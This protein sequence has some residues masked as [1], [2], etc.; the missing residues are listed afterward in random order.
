MNISEFEKTKKYIQDTEKI[1]FDDSF[2]LARSCSC[3]LNKDKTESLGRELVI[4]ILE[5]IQ[6][7][8]KRTHALWNDLV[9]VSGLEPYVDKK[10]LR[11]TAAIRH[12]YH[13]SISLPDVYLHREQLEL[14]SILHSG[15]S[16]IV[17]A[18]TS[19]GKS[20][21]IEEIV[22]S[23]LY[24]NIVIIQPT[25]ALL[26]ETRK[27]LEKYRQQ[28]HIVVSTH[29]RPSSGSNIFLLT[30]ERVVDYDKFPPIDFFVIDE[31]YKLSLE[32]DDERAV[33]L[34]QALY[35]LLKMTN[36]F[37]L[38]GPNIKRISQSFIDNYKALWHYSDYATVAVDIEHVYKD[39]N[40]T[41]RDKRREKALFRLL[42]SFDE[43]TM[44]YCSSP[45]KA[46][47][48]AS[49][50]LSYLNSDQPDGSAKKLPKSNKEIVEWINENIHQ[51]WILGE[52]L[53]H[54]IAFHHG[55]LPRHLG[56]SI[57]DS[58]NRGDIKY[59]FCTS[60]LIEGVNTT[61][62][63]V[64]LFD[65][66]K[67]LKPID[68]FDYKNIVGRSGRMKYHF[69]GKVYEFHREPTQLEMEVD[70]PLFSQ[71]YAPLELIIQLDSKDVA[72]SAKDRLKDYDHLD[73]DLKAV[74][75]KNSGLPVAGQMLLVSEIET[76]IDSYYQL[77]KWTTI[78]TFAQLS[79]TIELCWR[80]LMKPKESKA[81]VAT[82][83]QL[84]FMTLQYHRGKSL[85]Y[86]IM[87]NMESPYWQ[88]KEP[89]EKNRVQKITHLVLGISRQWFDFK[90]PKLLAGI[91]EIQA[92]VFKKFSKV[93]GNY[94]Y[95]SAIIENSFF[96]RTL[97]VLMD[98]DVPASA[99]R[100]M[101]HLFTGEEDWLSIEK[102]LRSYDLESLDL[103]PY[104][105]KKLKAALNIK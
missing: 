96:K 24:K 19:F 85:K 48:L 79:T 15:K 31:F 23:R 55:Y 91:S 74:I 36:R 66:Q 37:Y 10:M 62:R 14:S 73:N 28:Y 25:L 13:E 4:R 93:P 49:G 99:I 104:E 67:G 92:Y 72:G 58:F 97:S 95:F 12:A 32:R 39:K 83:K 78:P 7:V 3:L 77:L 29:Q 2:S 86:M 47:Q 20:L 40:W 11:G 27:K 102:K 71:E 30:G 26:D 94:S 90:L 21:L 75:R 101:E 80:F 52:A 82:P 63:N 42:Q 54:N 100:K 43:S 57:V 56:S 84:A 87:A 22:A 81:G 17:S 103:L 59:L 98:Y 51:E 60:T 61:A 69:V 41:Y 1:N 53:Q 16:V 88:E 65:K 18:P 64:V 5:E 38:L 45:D 105:M 6:K 89:N 46:T 68:F 33:I 44:I 9:E 34:N 70:V 76:N 50:F 8:D 35:R